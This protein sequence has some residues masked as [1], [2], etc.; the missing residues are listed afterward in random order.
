MD[1]LFF[2]VELSLELEVI[3]TFSFSIPF[4]FRSYILNL[5]PVPYLLQFILV[6]FFLVLD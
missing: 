2:L 4:S 1:L 6:S 5:T 3:T